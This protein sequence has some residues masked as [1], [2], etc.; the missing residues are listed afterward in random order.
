MRCDAAERCQDPAVGAAI[1]RAPQVSC[2][3]IRSLIPE[4]LGGWVSL[5]WPS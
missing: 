1:A 2:A 3:E 4:L 5:K